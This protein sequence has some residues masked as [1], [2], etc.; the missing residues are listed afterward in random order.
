VASAASA[1][2]ALRRND[3]TTLRVFKMAAAVGA[4]EHVAP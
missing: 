3:A 2:T 1:A 4:S